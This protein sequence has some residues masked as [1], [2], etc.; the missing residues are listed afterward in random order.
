M[1]YTLTFDLYWLIMYAVG[2]LFGYFVGRR[3]PREDVVEATIDYLI[4]NNLVK[5][6]EDPE[7]GEVELIPL[8]DTSNR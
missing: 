7:T 4:D 1:D 5:W 3:G 8:D 6:R 2:T